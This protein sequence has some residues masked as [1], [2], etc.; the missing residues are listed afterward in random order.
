MTDAPAT[1]LAVGLLG[2]D[3]RMGRAVVGVLAAAPG[4][5]LAAAFTQDGSPH[6]GRDAG[7]V[8]GVAATGATLQPFNADALAGCDVLIDFSTPDATR[9]A[10]LAMGVGSCQAIVTGT[11]G[12]GE[13][14]L[15]ELHD[16]ARG[17]RFL[18]AGNFSLG[19]NLMAVLV[20]Q[21]AKAL[22]GWDV[23]LAEAHHRH[24]VD[25]P[26]GTAILLGEA[27]AR[28]RGTGLTWENERA[29]ERGPGIGLS[30][31][32]S[33]GIIGDH[34]VSFVSEHESLSL[35]HRALDRSLFAQ[36]ALEA[37]RWLATQAPGLYG[38]RDVLGLE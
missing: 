20:E 2:A 4:A 36:G 38:M 33:G 14:E 37:A 35:S 1:S 23:E 15:A 21:A 10:V 16:L 31:V 19:V 28:G 9:A 7:E 34:A 32:R 11:T 13:A 6:L 25:S 12:Q 8:A 22:P 24:K 17:L 5:H 27:A 29:G 18:R 26:S 3:G 30:V